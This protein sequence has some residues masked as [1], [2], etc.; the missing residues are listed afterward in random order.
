MYEAW[1]EYMYCGPEEALLPPDIDEEPW[2]WQELDRETEEGPATAQCGRGL[3]QHTAT[4][5]RCR[6]NYDGHAYRANLLKE[7]TKQA[8]RH[9]HVD[10]SA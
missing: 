4:G 1:P 9:T 7:A 2:H 5:A 6:P 8:G 3:G 10:A